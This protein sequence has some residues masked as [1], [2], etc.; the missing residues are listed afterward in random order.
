[1]KT[2]AV[3]AVI[4]TVNVVTCVAAIA[5]DPVVTAAALSFAVFRLPHQ[6]RSVIL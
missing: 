6:L 5:V 3:A 4:I 1:M 2:V